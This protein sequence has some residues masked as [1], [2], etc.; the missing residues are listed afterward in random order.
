MDLDINR[1]FV[2]SD[3]HFGSS[4]FSFFKVFSSEEEDILVSKWNSVV[5]PG[6]FVVYNG[7]FCDG[8][9]RCLHEFRSR[10]NGHILLVKGNHDTLPESAYRQEFCDV[11]KNL[12]ICGVHFT[13]KPKDILPQVYG[14]VHRGYV[15]GPLDKKTSF[16]S[17]VQAHDGFPVPLVEVLKSLDVRPQ[18]CPAGCLPLHMSA[19]RLQ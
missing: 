5:S 6:D 18:T 3:H 8:D 15:V 11:V 4:V 16:C 17:C 19:S 10:L 12:S 9:E 2:T 7:D 13:H 14:H 1:T